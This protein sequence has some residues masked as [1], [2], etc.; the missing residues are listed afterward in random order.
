MY[1]EFWD[2]VKFMIVMA[3]FVAVIWTLAADFYTDQIK[4]LKRKIKYYETHY[5]LDYPEEEEN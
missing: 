3:G 1:G 4:S 2:F 5:Y